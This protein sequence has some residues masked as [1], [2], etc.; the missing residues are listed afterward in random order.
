MRI[1]DWSSDVCSSD[2]PEGDNGRAGSGS[3]SSLAKIDPDRLQ[4]GVFLH[5]V[6]RLIAAEAGL[7]VAANARSHVAGIEPVTP[8]HAG[9]QPLLTAVR[10]L[11]LPGH[12]TP[13]LT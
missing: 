6:Q 1:S 2:L 5:R 3:A 8:H 4:L 11:L 13:R 9:L 10:L 12:P 7:L